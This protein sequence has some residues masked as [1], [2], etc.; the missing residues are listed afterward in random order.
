MAA[1]AVP[2][3]QRILQ[4]LVTKI[5]VERLTPPGEASHPEP[6]ATL[7]DYLAV[8]ENRLREV[9]TNPIN[10][11]RLP[12]LQDL[13]ANFNSSL[14]Q[15]MPRENTTRKEFSKFLRVCLHINNHRITKQDLG[16]FGIQL[17]FETP[18]LKRIIGNKNLLQLAG[19][20]EN[21]RLVSCICSRIYN[22]WVLRCLSRQ[23]D[24]KKSKSWIRRPM[25]D[26]LQHN[27]EIKRTIE[28]RYWSQFLDNDVSRIIVLVITGTIGAYLGGLILQLHPN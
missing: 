18:M 24:T 26:A 25:Y 6:N 2:R 10:H 21:T 4:L 17:Q 5:L 7:K 14:L 28:T 19:D 22:P 3:Y 27:D 20:R 8:L 9:F 11:Q 12:E 16:S 1:E 13:E 23:P 15:S